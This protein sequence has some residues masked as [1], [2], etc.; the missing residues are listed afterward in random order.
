MSECDAETQMIFICAV[1]EH[2]PFWR[3]IIIEKGRACIDHKWM[4][5]GREHVSI[6]LFLPLSDNPTLDEAAVAA[7]FGLSGLPIVIVLSSL[8]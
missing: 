6:L 5:K 3:R 1:D 2:E 8:S 4:S 7:V